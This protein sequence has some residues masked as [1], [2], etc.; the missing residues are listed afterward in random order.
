M[1]S[2]SSNPLPISLPRF[3]PAALLLALALAAML[4]MVVGIAAYTVH[5]GSGIS[6]GDLAAAQHNAYQSGH[7]AGYTAGLAKGKDTGQNA[8]YRQGKHDGMVAG[9]K[10]GRTA[11]IKKGRTAGY[12]SGYAAG[13]AAAQA[14]APPATKTTKKKTGGN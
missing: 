11:G 12:A 10:K 14:A 13:V 3:S 1:S 9:I 4:S 5:T 8:G 6:Q 7:D 2:T